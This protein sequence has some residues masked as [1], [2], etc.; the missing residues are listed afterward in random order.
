LLEHDGV[1]LMAGDGLDAW[2]TCAW[3]VCRQDGMQGRFITPALC[4]YDELAAE[5]RSFAKAFS[6]SLLAAASF[7]SEAGFCDTV[8]PP[9]GKVTTG[10]LAACAAYPW[11]TH[12]MHQNRPQIWPI[13]SSTKNPRLN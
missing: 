8:S 11:V 7:S 1:F 6:S 9:S 4:E 2:E 12:H 13:V 5:S 10:W 3:A